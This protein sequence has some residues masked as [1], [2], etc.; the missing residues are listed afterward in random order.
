[1]P[2]GRPSKLTPELQERICT[3]IRAGNYYRAAC[4]YGGIDY[5]NFRV[6][7][8]KGGRGRGGKYREF[9]DA[10][11]RAEADAE[12][13]VVALWRQQIPENWQAARDFLARRFPKRWGPKD[14]HE[15]EHGGGLTVLVEEVIVHAGEEEANA[16]TN[17]QVGAR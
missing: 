17:G 2:G 8:L 14:K 13:A 9:H 4:R 1:V 11:L 5:A 10:V 15:H 7:M 6:W 12:V 16:S 3:A